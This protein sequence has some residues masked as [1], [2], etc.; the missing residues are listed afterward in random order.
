MEKLNMKIPKKKTN[1]K[2]IEMILLPGILDVIY[3]IKSD[4]KDKITTGMSGRKISPMI[5]NRIEIRCKPFQYR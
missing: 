1:I 3:A 4:T 2:T 5:K